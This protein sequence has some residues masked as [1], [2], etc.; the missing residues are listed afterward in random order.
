MTI[1][2]LTVVEDGGLAALFGE[3]SPSPAATPVRA[4]RTPDTLTFVRDLLLEK[5]DTALLDPVAPASERNPVILGTLREAIGQQSERGQG[6]L[7]A[8]P[9]DEESLL[10]LFRDTLGWGPAQPYLD[11]E[12]VQEVK[13][14]GERIMVQEDGSDFVLV[15]ER[16]RSPREPLDRAVVLADKLGV[17]LDRSRPQG[18]LPLAHGTRMHVTIPP[19]TPEQNALIC[20]RRGRR[21]AWQLD[22]VLARGAFSREVYDLLL[23]FARARCSFIV[24]GET[25]SGKTALLEALV[26]S[27]PGEPHVITIEDNT[28]EINVRHQAW[29]RE[30]VQTSVEPGAFGR[31]AKEA[32]R[33][34][35]SLVAPGETRAE[36]AGAILTVAVS[37]H[38]VVTTLH[39]KSCLAAI[40]RFADCAAMP[41]AYVYEGRRDN[42][43][44]DA[45]DNIE[46]V[47]HVEK[48][49]GRRYIGEIALLDGADRSGRQA[50]PQL[51]PLVEAVLDDTGQLT[52][53]CAASAEGDTLRWKSGKERT[54]SGIAQKLRL[55]RAA[56]Q[57]RAAPTTRAAIEEALSRAAQALKADQAD[58]A[59]A[60]LR[61]VWAERRDERLVSA[62]A[63]VLE[64]SPA[65]FAAQAVQAAQAATAIDAALAA[66]RWTLARERY[67]ALQQELGLVAAF[68]PVGGW[69]TLETAIQRGQAADRQLLDRVERARSALASAR[70]Q[71]ALDLLGSTDLGRVSPT[72]AACSLRVRH[73]AVAQLVETGELSQGALDAVLTQLQAVEQANA[74]LS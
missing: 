37:G 30:L 43:L 3:R 27:W 50:R 51:V 16:F 48:I 60:A 33:Q 61:R 17:A 46:L 2:P 18:T 42:A 36:E 54:P 1:R 26:N 21:Y 14:I 57:V 59:L 23:L 63:R 62:A 22:D 28:L 49:G 66:R 31:A 11:D 9:T 19:C 64:H 67:D 40:Q 38:A 24:A 72:A 29:T 74:A 4:L 39:A 68:T 5:I 15:P 32:L 53:R 71:D 10:A 52:W 35:P 25:G 12:R 6:V 65:T 44:E 7:A 13:I 73:D 55:L 47:V 56:S 70:A 20:I 34:T 8:L 45:C 41:G 58:L 69:S